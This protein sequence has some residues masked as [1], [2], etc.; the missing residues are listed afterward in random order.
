MGLKKKEIVGISIILIIAIAAMFMM[1]QMQQGTAKK[2]V[3][4]VGGSI[5]KQIKLNED[6]TTH[7]ELGNNH[8]VD[9]V[10]KDG[11]AHVEHSTCPDSICEKMGEIAG[12][13]ETIVCLPNKV[14][15]Y[16][17]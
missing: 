7:I 15:V 5:Y 9:V 14:L 12:P 13:E 17:K 3:V 11:K 8:S 2:A 6:S 4:E 1:N 10:V 16:V